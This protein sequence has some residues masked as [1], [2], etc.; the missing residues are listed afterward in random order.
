MSI[1]GWTCFHGLFSL[2][3]IHYVWHSHVSFGVGWHS[4]HRDVFCFVFGIATCSSRKHC[5]AIFWQFMSVLCSRHAKQNIKYI[6]ETRVQILQ[7]IC[8]QCL[9]FSV[10]Y[11]WQCTWTR[12]VVLQVFFKTNINTFVQEIVRLG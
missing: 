3:N 11:C 12:V 8:F 2:Y 5:S 4:N 6:Y 10:T 7:S 1:Y 9:N